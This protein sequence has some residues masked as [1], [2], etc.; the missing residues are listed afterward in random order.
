[1]DTEKLLCVQ[2]KDYRNFHR[3]GDF[4][5]CTVCTNETLIYY[6]FSESESIEL[7]KQQPSVISVE[8]ILP[9]LDF[10][11]PFH[12]ILLTQCTNGIDLFLKLNGVYQR[13]KPEFLEFKVKQ[14][15]KAIANTEKI[16]LNFIA[17]KK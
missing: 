1:M 17:I 6:A 2:C 13:V 3:D 8:D 16:L 4:L 11:G 12:K 10:N 15:K 14:Y 9:T 5:K 7:K